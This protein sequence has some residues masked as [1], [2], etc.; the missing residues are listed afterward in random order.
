MSLLLVAGADRRTNL[1]AVLESVGVDG[2]DRERQQCVLFIRHDSGD[3]SQR[4]VAFP[5]LVL[6]TRNTISKQPE[7]KCGF[8]I[9]FVEGALPGSE[10]VVV[11]VNA[12]VNSMSI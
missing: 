5:V 12:D 9:T 3:H 4:S 1:T 10:D 6:R 2:F 11:D 7:G 8:A